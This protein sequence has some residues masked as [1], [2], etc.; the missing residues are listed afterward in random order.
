MAAN[1][2]PIRDG[3]ANIVDEVGQPAGA[4]GHRQIEGDFPL[5]AHANLD[6]LRAAPAAPG[7]ES[8]RVLHALT[9]RARPASLSA[10]GDAP[11]S[12]RRPET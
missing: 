4:A 2:N 9:G 7:G 6:R 8:E 5:H 1:L 10:K 12:A 3:F 11:V